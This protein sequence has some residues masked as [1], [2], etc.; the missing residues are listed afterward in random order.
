[1]AL[2]C[3]TVCWLGGGCKLLFGLVVS[4]GCC[5]GSSRMITRPEAC[6]TI[7]TVCWRCM[8]KSDNALRV[9]PLTAS[10]SSWVVCR[11]R[12]GLVGVD[13]CPGAIAAESEAEGRAKKT[14]S[15]K[16]NG[17]VC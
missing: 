4:G 13:V 1:M 14:F 17:V 16:V 11:L 7:L 9:L 15:A 2:F 6:R 8:G 3:A 12:V 10:S 5:C